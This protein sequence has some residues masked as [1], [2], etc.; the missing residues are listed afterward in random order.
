MNP[1]KHAVGPNGYRNGMFT[2]GGNTR[3]KGDPPVKNINE[4][5]GIHFEL[6]AEKKVKFVGKE[7][8]GSEF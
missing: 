5:W 8:P 4:G 1:L 6:N 7:V 3:Q 2:S